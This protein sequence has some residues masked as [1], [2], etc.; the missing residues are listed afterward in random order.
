MAEIISKETDDVETLYKYVQFCLEK[1]GVGKLYN[2]TLEKLTKTGNLYFYYS[3][4]GHG[5]FRIMCY[6]NLHTCYYNAFEPR[7]RRYIHHSIIKGIPNYIDFASNN[8]QG[9]VSV[10]KGILKIP[11]NLGV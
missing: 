4:Q 5:A 3:T 1:A 2:L 8:E 10:P 9:F 6:I 7:C 11:K